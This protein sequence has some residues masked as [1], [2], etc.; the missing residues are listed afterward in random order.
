ML[1]KCTGLLRNRQFENEKTR[2]VEA[3]VR[4]RVTWIET[5]IKAGVYTRQS[6]SQESLSRQNSHC[7]ALQ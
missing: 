3:L 1:C 4:L 6:M 2:A 5:K 7:F